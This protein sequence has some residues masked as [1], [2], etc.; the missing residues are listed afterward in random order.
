MKKI[1]VILLVF[2]LNCQK[3]PTPEK[4]VDVL[5][6]GAGIMSAT[7]ATILSQMDSG[8]TIDIYE[9]LEGAA[10]ESSEA[11][12]NAGTGHAGFCELNYTPELADGTIDTKK[13]RAINEEF[14]L[15]QE[16]WTYLVKKGIV[17]NPKAFIRQVPHISLVFGEK[18]VDFL[19]RRFL[20]LK[21]SP[22]FSDIDYSENFSQIKSWIPLSMEGR[23]DKDMV[24]A[25]RYTKGTDVNFGSLTKGQIDFLQKNHLANVHFNSEVLDIKRDNDQ[26]WLVTI[27]D[28]K[29]KRLI[30]VKAKKIFIGAGGKSLNLLQKT[31]VPEA[32]GLGGFPVGG[33]WLISDKPEVIKNHHAK[34]YGKAALGA[35]PMSVPHLDS[36]Y[37]DGK[38]YVLFGPFATF[39]TKFLKKGSYFD[40]FSSI[41]FNNIKPMLQAGF[42]NLDLTKYLIG[43]LLLS[44][45]ERMDALRAYY[46]NA[47]DEDWRLAIAGQRVQ[48]IKD[49]K[50][51]GGILQ[52]GTEIISSDDGTITA[53]LGASPGASVAV[54]AMLDVMAKAFKDEMNSKNWSE[55]LKAMMPSLGQNLENDPKFLHR[56]REHN[57][58]ILLQLH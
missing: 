58:Q 53:L 9:R 48:I 11:W 40:L 7:L 55:K 23:N 57:Q 3:A 34:V 10:L 20:A 49:D 37:I 39:S 26:L 56:V 1:L 30:R 36:R 31:K 51:K 47:K 14:E 54:K 28:I 46:P 50:E 52:F 24:A 15:S 41:T 13:A 17:E 18:D 5:L 43:Q 6:V 44:P 35:P 4:T 2:S 32:L 38:E 22:L 16:F 33:M 27:N 21:L 29:E 8:L 25:T 12:N 19:K 45:K 42:K